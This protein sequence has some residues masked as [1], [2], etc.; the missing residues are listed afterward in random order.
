MASPLRARLILF[1]QVQHAPLASLSCVRSVALAVFA[2]RAEI[3]TF[4]LWHLLLAMRCQLV[5]SILAGTNP[6]VVKTH[7]IQLITRT[8]LK[9]ML[10]IGFSGARLG[11]HQVAVSMSEPGSVAIGSLFYATHWCPPH[12]CISLEKHLSIR[13]VVFWVPHARA[14]FNA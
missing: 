7:R 6:Y 10:G 8:C 5:V 1:H 3:G 12:D 14:T 2:G 13:G 9:T 4:R 11:L